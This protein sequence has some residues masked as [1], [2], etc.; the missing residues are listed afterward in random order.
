[1]HGE[2][3]YPGGVPAYLD[4][5]ATA[6]LRPAAREAWLGH[7]GAPANP[8]SL[9]AAGRAASRALEDAREQIAQ[10]AGAAP[11]DILFTSGGTEASVLALRGLFA[12][13]DR[14][15]VLV[16]AT[17]HKAVLD[18]ARA[19]PGA[20]VEEVPVDRAGRLD[21]A[22]LQSLLDGD[23]ALVAVMAANNEVGT[24]NDVAAIAEAC[25]GAGAALHCDAV[26]WPATRVEALDGTTIALS[27]HKLGGPVGVGAVVLRGVDLPIYT[28][29]GLQERGIRSGTVDVA[30]IAAFAA[31][32]DDAHRHR[33]AE[34]SRI[35]A[36]R[37]RLQD[38]IVA[39]FPDAVVN[40]AAAP[41][42]DSH[43]NVTFPGCP[44]DALLMLCDAA[45][46][47]VSTGSA[48]TLGI[49]K[50]S[51]VL[52]AMGAHEADASSALRFSLGWAS[53]S[54]DVDAALAALGPAVERARLA[55]AADRAEV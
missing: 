10:L 32:W 28:H 27:A 15:R 20:T 37:D 51:H 7:T 52:Q 3:S 6:P 4:Y 29:G 24:I 48:C 2:G 35:R 19:L 45:G 34:V 17:E 50:P 13:S 25:R 18:T 53:T 40:G 36:L 22:A 55:G 30:G 5:A 47:A 1:M 26:Q 33:G 11:Q 12:A 38:G 23:V 31:A 49:P 9:H 46:V 41:R 16:G 43:L 42:L 39:Q 21:L 44:A 54:Q 14:P 8:A